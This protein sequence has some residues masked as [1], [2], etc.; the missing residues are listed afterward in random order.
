MTRGRCP[1][2]VWRPTANFGYI[3]KGAHGENKPLMICSHIMGGYKRTLDDPGWREP[4]GVGVHFGIGKDG[5]ISQYTNIFDASWGNGLSGSIQKYDRSNR[6]LAALEQMPGAMWSTHRYP[7]YTAYSLNANGLN[8]P[9][10]HT[11]SIE[12]EGVNQNDVWTEEMVEATIRVHRWIRD[13][14]AAA[15]M[16]LTI[17]EDVLI[18]H[19][20]IDGVH[21]VYCPGPQWPKARILAALKDEEEDDMK[22]HHAWAAWFI[23]REL[24]PSN[25]IYT[26]QAASDFALPEDARAVM[27][28]VLTAPGTTVEF[29]HGD[30][31]IPVACTGENTY[32]GNLHEG[33]LNFRARQGA[34]I[35]N[36]HCVGYFR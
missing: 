30:T 13:E 26:M 27:F 8:L 19:F 4:A 25:D 9:N 24:G 18:G 5:S 7:T 21:R 17:D 36:V 15:D 11:V 33:T 14:L 32:V 23:N 1:F 12:H 6:H 22:A 16:P 20:Q 35:K 3:R 10:C 34:V 31:D 2:A 28:Q 29:F